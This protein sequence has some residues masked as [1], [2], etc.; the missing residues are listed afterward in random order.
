MGQIPYDEVKLHLVRQLADVFLKAVFI[1]SFLHLM[2]RLPH[3]VWQPNSLITLVLETVSFILAVS[4]RAFSS[5][6]ASSGEA[7]FFG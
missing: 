7:A 3:F 6:L 2:V 5:G 1:N 4:E